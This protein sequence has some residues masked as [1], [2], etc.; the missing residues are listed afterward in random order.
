MQMLQREDLA[1]QPSDLPYP[2]NTF[3][4]SPTRLSA[5]EGDF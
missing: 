3:L 2:V 4:G 5:G 1:C